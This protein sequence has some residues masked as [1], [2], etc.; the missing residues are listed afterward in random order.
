MTYSIFKSFF[1]IALCLTLFSS[2]THNASKQISENTSP[3]TKTV[4]IN[5]GTEPP[6]LDPAR[7]TDLTSFT[8][9]QPLLKGLTQ[10]D[11]N[12]KAVPAIAERW[13]RSDDGLHYHFYLRKN[14][15]WSDGKSVTAHDFAYAW[16]RVLDPN[17][18]AEYGFF[19]FEI[20][21]ARAFYEKKITDFKN[22][23]IRVKNKHEL[24]V[25]LER[26][27]PFFLD[28]MAAPIALPLRKDVV[29]K[30]G[31]SFTEAG[32]F[33]TNGA[34]QLNRWTHEDRIVLTPNPYFYGEQPQVD[35]VIMLMVNDANTSVVMYEN[36]ELD[37]IETSTS[38]PSFDVRRL[39]ELPEA[40]INSI[41]RLNYFGFNVKKPP[42]DDVRVRQAFA[43][44]IDKTY[45]PKLMKS[46][47]KPMDSIIT[48][49][50]VGHNAE[51]GL[52]F[53]PERAKALL[54]EAG[55]PE[56]KGF[57]EISLGFRTGYD[58]QKECEIAQYQ[59]KTHLNV[60]VRLENMEW[61]VFLSRLRQDSPHIFRLGWFVD[62]P[63]ADSFMGIFIG[64]SG[65]NNTNW[66]NPR[67]DE[68][69][70]KAVVTIDESE[71]QAL[72][73]EA[74]KLILETD[75]VLTPIY[76]AEKLWLLKS[77]VKGL[78]IN[79]MNLINIDGLRVEY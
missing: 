24:L 25:D 47:Q 70:N 36:D 18:P 50:L 29:E 26:P 48:P 61:K 63:D 37:F 75:T 11:A 13:T 66:K 35:S 44:A 68:L 51:R 56:G 73:D 76:Q 23:G 20:K 2:C 34:Y 40:H 7:M 27:T 10:F 55:Y 8:V 28:L 16:Q 60:D 54:A 69:V 77:H 78:K 19:L 59:W 52:H 30:H 58:Q 71:R 38:I 57:P 49:G 65:N 45:Y 62:Y 12:L 1:S 43:M 72:Y 17:M 64:D 32:N 46:G 33:L 67:Y 22:V 4:R 15:K 21:N 6:S 9:I 39:R 74:Q 5:L 14:A 42:F 31:D 79:D 3:N 41:H 53:N